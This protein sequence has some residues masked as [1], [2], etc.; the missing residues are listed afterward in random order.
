[1]N[2]NSWVWRVAKLNFCAKQLHYT[3]GLIPTDDPTPQNYRVSL[4][5]QS[6][7]FGDSRLS[8][9]EILLLNMFRIFEDRQVKPFDRRDAS[10]RPNVQIPLGGPNQTLSETRV[11]PLMR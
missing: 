5:R 7:I 3:V 11:Y 9:T 10:Y 8:M 4:R 1:M 2:K 6:W